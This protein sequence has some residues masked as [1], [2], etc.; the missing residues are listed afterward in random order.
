MKFL[1]LQLEGFG[2]DFSDLCLRAV[3]L[4]KRGKFFDLASWKDLEMEEGV[5]KD[6]EIQ[7]EEKLIKYIKEIINKI[8]GEKLKTKYVV[9]SLPEK[10]AFLQVIKVP[11]MS[12]EELASA[13][14]FEAE[15]Y[16]PLP[17][18]D[19]YLDFQ[20]VSSAADSADHFDILIAALPKE[21]IDSYVYCI[22]KAGLILKALE[23]ES[24]SIVRALIKNN[25]SPFPVFIIDFGRSRTGFIIFSDQ[26]LRFTSSISISSHQLSELVAKEFK[27]TIPEA[28]KMKLKYGLHSSSGGIESKRVAQSITPLLLEMTEEAKKYINYYHNHT[29]VP[30]FLGGGKIKKVL[31]CGRGANLFDLPAFIASDLKIP[32]ER[33]NPW[34]NILSTSVKKVPK[35]EFNE[36]LGYTTAL[37][38]A[39]RAIQE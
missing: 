35:L 11:K 18:E 27:I 14:P 15:N 2:L 21:T 34:I 5:I 3:K 12:L 1:S 29:D 13:I 37:G 36:S 10:K 24:Q 4:K 39:L 20:M 9:A 6:G 32:V 25:I 19:M 23:V 31:L 22:K 8:E 30:D 7:K 28:E 33:A 38:L 16:I 26:S 17:I